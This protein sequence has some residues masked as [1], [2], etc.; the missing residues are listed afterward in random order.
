MADLVYGRICSGPV[1]AALLTNEIRLK[2]GTQH[3]AASVNLFVREV[4]SC[5]LHREDVDV[6]DVS[7]AMFVSWNLEPWA[8]DEKVGAL[9]MS[10]RHDFHDS[11]HVVF[12]IKKPNQS[13]DPALA[14]VTHPAGQGA[15]HP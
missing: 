2:W 15:R 3:P 7:E 13:P 4:A 5:L 14:S 6:G 9:L 12:A 11:Q 1:P 8:A 10:A